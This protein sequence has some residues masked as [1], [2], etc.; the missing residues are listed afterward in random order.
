MRENFSPDEIVN[1]FGTGDGE[2]ADGEACMMAVHSDDKGTHTFEHGDGKALVV[3][4]AGLVDQLS[5]YTGEK[6]G[7]ILREVRK[8]L[9]IAGRM[10][11]RR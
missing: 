4:I 3:C 7:N 9:E 11:R 6:P 5:E 1:F 8:V 10:R 2:T